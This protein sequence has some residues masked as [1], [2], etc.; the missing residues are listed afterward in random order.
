MWIDCIPDFT[1][2]PL[3]IWEIPEGAV[4]H[5]VGRGSGMMK[6]LP[7]EKAKGTPIEYRG[8]LFLKFRGSLISQIDEIY[9]RTYQDIS[10]F[11]AYDF[12]ED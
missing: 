2:T 4:V 12:R 11:S 3:G 1:M 5:F 9:T 10:H 8:S 6:D 7:T